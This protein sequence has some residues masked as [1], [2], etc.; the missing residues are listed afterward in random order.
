MAIEGN[1]FFA[2]S[3]NGSKIYTRAGAFYSD[4]DGYVVNSPVPTCRVMRWMPT[5]R[6]SRAC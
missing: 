3:D 2:L 4:K 1:G 5:A 6:S